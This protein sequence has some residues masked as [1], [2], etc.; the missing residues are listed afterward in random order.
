MQK[1][2]HLC[3]TGAFTTKDTSRRFK[4]R[5]NDNLVNYD[6]PSL[7]KIGLNNGKITMMDA[8]SMDANRRLL[9]E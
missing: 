7:V 9:T 3:E 4:N 8:G 2:A 1:I 5:K 6:F